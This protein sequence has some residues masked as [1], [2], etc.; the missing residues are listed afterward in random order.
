MIVVFATMFLAVLVSQLLL[1]KFGPKPPQPQS[2]PSV[3][4]PAATGGPSPAHGSAQP[5][6]ANV[7]HQ[8]MLAATKTGAVAKATPPAAPTVRQASAETETV[9]ENGL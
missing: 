2:Q 5:Q 8:A 1:T 7:G 3:E 4:Q 9:V 6:G